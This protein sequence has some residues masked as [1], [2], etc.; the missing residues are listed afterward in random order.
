MSK[1]E[2]ILTEITKSNPFSFFAPASPSPSNPPKST[3]SRRSSASS[4]AHKSGT[5]SRES[6]REKDEKGKKRR[7]TISMGSV[8]EKASDGT[9]MGEKL[10]EGSTEITAVVLHGPKDLR[11]VGLLQHS[12]HGTG[13]FI[14]TFF[15]HRVFSATNT[16]RRNNKS[17]RRPHP[18][19]SASK[20]PA[21]PSAARTCI[22][23][24]PSATAPFPHNTPSS[25][26]MNHAATSPPSV[27]P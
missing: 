18:T 13:F 12:S 23:T 10:E 17:T 9:K 6:S 22:T 16:Q 24:H 11:I 1:L 19:K 3:K 21:Q 20:S 25:S 14:S 15:Y 26:G 5:S 7:S 27:P 8:R 2:T 4:K